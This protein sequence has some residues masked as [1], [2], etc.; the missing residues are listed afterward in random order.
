MREFDA[1]D[2]PV[3]A[4]SYD[5]AD[6][7]SDFRDAH[8]ITFTLLS[9]PQSEVIRSFGILNTLIDKNDHPWFGIP[10]PGTFVLDAEGA[11]T[12]KFFDS[13]LAVRAG[14]EQLL[15]AVQGKA[16]HANTSAA[17]QQLEQGEVQIDISFDGEGLTPV[18]QN[19]LVVK[20][21]VPHGRHV[22]AEPAPAGSVAANIVVDELSTL[23]SRPI[24]RPDGVSHQL[25]GTAEVFQVHNDQFE[26]RLPLTLNEAVA[27]QGGNITISGEVCWQVCDNEVCDVPTK[28][29]FE[30]ALPVIQS[31]ANAL[32]GRGA[33]LEPSAKSHFQKMTTRRA[34]AD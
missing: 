23:V 34:K 8:N 27:D 18:V 12:H 10:Y 21:M 20:F 2:I 22:Y 6:A 7:L 17:P 3:Y 25:A 5:E 16:P 9:D 14:P 19:D 15:R 11:I 4:L 26:L 33:E 1:L 24:V 28:K 13:N 30:L 31:P 32:G 29:P